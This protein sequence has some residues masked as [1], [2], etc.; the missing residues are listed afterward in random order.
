MEIL[1]YQIVIGA[2]I[3]VAAIV[4]GEIG[5]KYATIGAVVWTVFH[6]FMPWLML[7]Q[8][9]T[10]ALAFGIGNAIVQEE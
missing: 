3:V 1:I 8:F 6:I 7:L 2:I 5:L 10:I 9:V 4:K